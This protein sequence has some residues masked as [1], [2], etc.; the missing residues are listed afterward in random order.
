[1]PT[2]SSSRPTS[3]N[4]HDGVGERGAWR[5]A[6]APR[7]R[8]AGG[9]QRGAACLSPVP[10][11]ARRARAGPGSD[12]CARHAHS[13]PPRVRS[14]GRGPPPEAAAEPLSHGGIYRQ[15]DVSATH[16]VFVYG[17]DLWLVPREG[18]TAVPL[19][20]PAGVEAFPRFS[21]DGEARG[22]RRVVRRRRGDLRPAR[23]G[24]RPRARH[25]APRDGVP[26]RL[27]DQGRLLFTMSGLGGLRSASPGV[28]GGAR[29][30]SAR[31]VARP[32]RDVPV[33]R[34][35]RHAA[36]LH[37][38]RRRPAELE[39]LPRRDRPPTSGSSISSGGR[40]SA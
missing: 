30:R 35:G 37:P 18:G 17:D 5:A 32:V 19:A 31:A 21:P 1:M 3:A 10:S 6:C 26:L 34:R 8:R 22:L 29:G 2:T 33:A 9:R 27:D 12:P 20:S 38:Q 13:R 14:R 36:R 16:V 11:P 23:A 28:H 39:A 4:S 24:R 25:V 15:P 7:Q 40:R